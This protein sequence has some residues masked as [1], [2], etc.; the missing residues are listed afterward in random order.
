MISAKR[1]RVRVA[2]NEAK[3]GEEFVDVLTNTSPGG[4]RGSAMQ[5]EFAIFS[6]KPD[7]T[8]DLVN[9]AEYSSIL[10]EVRDYKER[11][12]N[13][14]MSKLIAV[15]DMNTALSV[16][17]WEAGTAQHGILRFSSLE[18]N[19]DLLGQ[20]SRDLWMAFSA[21]VAED[22][23]PITLGGARFVMGEDGSLID[24][25]SIPPLGAS[26]IPLG[27]AYDG[28]GQ[29]V[30]PVTAGKN[31]LWTKGANDTS[32]VNGTETVMASGSTFVAQGNSVTLTGTAGQLVTATVR[33]PVYLTADEGDARYLTNVA[34]V[35]KPAGVIEEYRSENGAWR[36]LEGVDNDGRPISQVEAVPI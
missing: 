9:V 13:L 20:N 1:N 35:I 26:L 10:C 36:R 17:E 21:V 11:T 4:W 18:T 34:R 2:I 3:R 31:H 28:I 16:S 12:S 22:A 19:I 6:R 32:V 7:L 25:R 8:D 30:L 15:A 23:E 5:V 24:A 27:A 33:Y 29:Y 14:L